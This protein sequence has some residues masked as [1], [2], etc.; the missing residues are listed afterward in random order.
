M[1]VYSVIASMV[2]TFD[3]REGDLGLPS[4]R[5][6]TR[7]K[8]EGHPEGKANPGLPTSCRRYIIL[9]NIVLSVE[10]N[11]NLTLVNIGMIIPYQLQLTWYD[12]TMP[13]A[14]SMV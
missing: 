1:Y 6:V 2:Y 4:P 3:K 5:D 12:H 8:P 10:I 11:P 13:V 7:A 14:T 9:I